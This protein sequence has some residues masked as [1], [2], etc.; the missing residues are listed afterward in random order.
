MIYLKEN[1]HNFAQAD[2]VAAAKAGILEKLIDLY[3][4]TMP[5][6]S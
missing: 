1:I 4:G 5:L 2:T 3:L 6:G